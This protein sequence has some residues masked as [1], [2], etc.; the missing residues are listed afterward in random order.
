MRFVP[1]PHFGIDEENPHTEEYLEYIDA[2]L[3]QHEW[4]RE[5]A[6]RNMK[7]VEEDFWRRV[8]EQQEKEKRY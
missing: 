5:C 2:V 6:R 4:E 3:K 1:E 8:N 7:K